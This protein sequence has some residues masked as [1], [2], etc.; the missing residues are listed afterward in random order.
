MVMLGVMMRIK[1][2]QFNVEKVKNLSKFSKFSKNSQKSQYNVQIAPERLLRESICVSND[3]LSVLK[4]VNDINPSVYTNNNN[5]N[6]L[7]NLNN[8]NN[9]NT[10]NNY[11]TQTGQNNSTEIEANDIQHLNPNVNQNTFLTQIITPRLIP[12]PQ[13]LTAPLDI[14]TRYIPQILLLKLWRSSA[15]DYLTIKFGLI[16]QKMFINFSTFLNQNDQNDQ[17]INYLSEKIIFLFNFYPQL[18]FHFTSPTHLFSHYLSRIV[19]QRITYMSVPD[20]CIHETN[21]RDK[22]QIEN[23]DQNNNIQTNL[24][25]S[26]QNSFIQPISPG[27]FTIKDF[28]SQYDFKTKH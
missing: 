2:I 10:L 16:F 4:R 23:V 25:S 26:Q 13:T 17:N 21:Y 22:D 15:V 24:N 11:E 3:L 28:I 8:L 1:K 12:T 27:T 7:N 19:L 5:L 9:L 14:A 18:L 20:S 6:T